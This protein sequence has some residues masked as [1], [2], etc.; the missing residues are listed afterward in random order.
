[1]LHSRLSIGEQADIWQGIYHGDYDIVV[2]PRSA[3][4]APLPDLGLII[5]DE[6]H[7]WAYKQ[8]DKIPRYNAR[9]VAIKMAE[10]TGATMIL[11]SATPSIE[12]YYKAQRSEYQL[13]ELTGA[14]YSHGIFSFT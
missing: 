13:V 11:G 9:D 12:T 3:I 6:E 5:V 10:L 8:T 14:C 4:F 7:E 2:G 1:M